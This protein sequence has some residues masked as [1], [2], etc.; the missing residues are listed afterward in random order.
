M[1][2]SVKYSEFSNRWFVYLKGFGQFGETYSS[3]EQAQEACDHYN[4]RII[5]A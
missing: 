1:K 2:Y 4:N 5:F 3:K